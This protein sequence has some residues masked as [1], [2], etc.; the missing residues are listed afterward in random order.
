M[1]NL[2]IVTKH[3][4]ANIS[5]TIKQ[6]KRFNGLM[7]DAIEIILIP[8]VIRFIIWGKFKSLPIQRLH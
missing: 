1:D 7:K 6:L 3:L 2:H 4:W 5:H 8:H